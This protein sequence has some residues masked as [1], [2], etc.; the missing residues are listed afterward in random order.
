MSTKSGKIIIGALLFVSATANAVLYWGIRLSGDMIESH[1]A[2]VQIL[3]SLLKEP[4]ADLS[5]SEVLKRAKM[6]FPS[7]EITI[8]KDT[9]VVASVRLYFKDG[10]YWGSSYEPR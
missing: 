1:L 2:T 10:V 5:M 4:P 9:I 7:T 3:E 8:D 6:I